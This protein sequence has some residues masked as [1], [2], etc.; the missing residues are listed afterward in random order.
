L[1][2]KP[3]EGCLIDS[4]IVMKQPVLIEI[5]KDTIRIEEGETVK[6]TVTMGAGINPTSVT[7][8]PS[9]FSSC[10]DCDTIEVRPPGTIT[11]T[12]QAIDSTGCGGKDAV[13]II[14][15][16]KIG[17]Y[18]PNA[19][20]PDREEFMV[21]GS[22]NISKIRKMQIFDRWGTLLYE[23]NNFKPDGTVGW[24]GMHRNT[25]M[26]RGTYVVSLE[27]EFVN[28]DI[29]PYSSEFLLSQ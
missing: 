27:I 8:S 2:I 24:N 7:W 14:V 19:F 20:N 9:Q 11:Y 23:A 13:Q 29:K 12:V 4:N 21:L 10:T 18:I 28:G 15:D 16:T 26:M 5:G 6:L 3:F 25:Q 22:S 1:V 17:L